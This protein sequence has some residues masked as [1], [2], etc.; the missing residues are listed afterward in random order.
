MALDFDMPIEYPTVF[1]DRYLQLFGL[2]WASN[3][4][5][6]EKEFEYLRMLALTFCYLLIGSYESIDLSSS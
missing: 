5:E 3:V 6:E 4:E 1:L 2:T